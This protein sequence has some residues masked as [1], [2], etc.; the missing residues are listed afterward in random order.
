ML[1]NPR[2]WVDRQP[3]GPAHLGAGVMSNYL[4]ARLCDLTRARHEPVQAPQQVRTVGVTMT[5]YARNTA[6][7]IAAAVLLAACSASGPATQTGTPTAAASSPAAAV[8]ASPSPAASPPVPAKRLTIR[9]A[10]RAYVRIL[11]PS[12]VITDAINRDATDAA[13]FS[14]YKADARA[15]IKAIRAAAGQIRALRWPVR[16]QPYIDAVL[17][18]FIP[19]N[20]RCN[21]AGIAAGSNTAASTVA[22]TN[23]NCLAASD[24]TLPDTIRSMLGLPP[25]S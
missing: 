1:R 9:Q 18:T 15:Y 4:E 23:Q 22:D 7:A 16:V 2:V 12:N 3:Q 17:L 13:P 5:T 21:K 10:T 19:A 24:S 11:D 14:R 20:I 25:R 8:T 6:A